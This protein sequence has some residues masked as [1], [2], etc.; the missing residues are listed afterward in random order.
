ML[1]RKNVLKLFNHSE[2]DGRMKSNSK[3]AETLSPFENFTKA[4]DGLMRVP[5]SAIKKAL[6]KEKRKKAEKKRAKN[7]PASDR[8]S[9]GEG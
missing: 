6:D 7:Q 8:V 1:A 9:G 2:Y 4:M 5:H 3:S